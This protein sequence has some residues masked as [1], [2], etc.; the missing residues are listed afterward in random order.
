[1]TIDVKSFK[2][3]I[4]LFSY[5][6]QWIPKFS[7]IIR[8]LITCKELPLQANRANSFHALKSLIEKTVNTTIESNTP[9][10]VETDTAFR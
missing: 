3:A 2:R 8:S 9:L 10:L 6:L 7:K 5:Y 1:M 4:G